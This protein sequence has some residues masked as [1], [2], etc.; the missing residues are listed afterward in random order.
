MNLPRLL[1]IIA[2]ALVAAFFIAAIYAASQGWTEDPLS[3]C[4]TNCA[5]R[6]K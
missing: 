1:T 2:L 6:G 5:S 3:L 4:G